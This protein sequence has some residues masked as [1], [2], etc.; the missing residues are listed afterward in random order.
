MLFAVDVGNTNIHIGF[1][2]KD[3]LTARFRMGTDPARADDEYAWMLQSLAEFNGVD[4]S[5]IEG[6]IIGSVVPSVTPTVRSAI[7]K[8]TT[9]P[10]LT[11]GPGIK[12]GFPIR[13]DDPAE[14]GADIAAT[15]AAT[16]ARVGAPAIVADFGTATVISAIDKDGAYVGSSILPG[17]QMSLDALHSA[18]L[19]PGVQS[20]DRTVPALGKNTA[21][22]MRAGVLRGEAMAVCGFAELYKKSLELPKDAPLVVSGGFAEYLLPYLPSD[23]V[24]IPLLT[25][26]G[27]NAIYRL[28]EK[29]KR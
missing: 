11:V 16:I 27:L 13:I 10:I 28:N 2:E 3:R 9:A 26:Q 29:K 4:L 1:F 12:T 17:I 19:L 18:E 14:L 15:V 24:H 8:I 20:S 23:T 6:V 22:C 5:R 21:D 7:R 25:L